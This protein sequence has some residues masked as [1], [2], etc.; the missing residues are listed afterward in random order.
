M[1]FIK[2]LHKS[3]EGEVLVLMLASVLS[4]RSVVALN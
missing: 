2:Q 3:N 1:F 4:F